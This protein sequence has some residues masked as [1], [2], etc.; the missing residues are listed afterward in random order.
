MPDGIV[1][2][3]KRSSSP[4][5]HRQFDPEGEDYDYYSA[6]KAGL[7]PDEKGHWQSRVPKTGLLLKGR[8]HKTWDLLEKGEAKA[9]FKIYRYKTYK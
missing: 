5:R 7:K 3:N 8:K 2:K 9:G 4:Y 6:H 1:R